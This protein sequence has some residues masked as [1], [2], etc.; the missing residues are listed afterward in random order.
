MEPELR[1]GDDSQGALGATYQAREVQRVGVDE[2]VEAVARDTTDHLREPAPYLVPVTVPDLHRP[3]QQPRDRVGVTGTS[4]GFVP[5]ERAQVDRLPGS[6]HA[7]QAE[8]LIR[9]HPVHERAHP[10]RVVPDHTP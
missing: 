8:D 1:A 3:A 2:S 5:I 4:S 7:A 6:E 9:S 10:S